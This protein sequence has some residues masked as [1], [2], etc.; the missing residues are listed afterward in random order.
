MISGDRRGGFNRRKALAA[1]VGGGLALSSLARHAGAGAGAASGVRTLRSP[2]ELRSSYDYVIVGAGSSGCVVAHRLG[3]AG[4]R[5][6]LLEAGG[7]ATLAAIRNPPEW[8]KL[9]GS[10]FD[11]RYLTVPQAGLG[12]RMIR[13]PRGK[14]V[15]GSS[16]INA[17]AY[18]RGHPAAYD[19]WPEGWRVADLLPYFKRAETFSGGAGAWR[20]G[21]GPLHVLSLADVRDRNPVAS[22]FV[23]ASQDLGYPMTSDIGG[24]L[25]TGVGWNQLNIKDGAR[26]DAATAYLGSLKSDTVD[27]LVDTEV[28]GLVIEGGRCSGVRLAERSVRAERE[29]LLCAGA[30]DSPRLLMLSGIGPADQL[31]SFNIPVVVDL[32]DVGRHLE[33]HLLVAGVAYAARREVPRSHY[34]HADAVL[35]VPRT[36]PNDSPEHL[37][38]CLSLPFVLSGVGPLPAPAYV[39]VSC[40]MRPRSRGSVKL[41]SGHPRAPALIDPNYLSEPA[42]L[43]LLVEGV[44]LAREIGASA[45]FAD[46]RT[47]EVYPGPKA[48]TTGD[49]RKFVV[50][51]TDSFHHPVGTCRIGAVV[52]QAL[53]VK[54]VAG[55]RVIDASVF[56]G[57]PQAMT[58]AA[59]IAVAEKAS[60]LVLAG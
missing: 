38:M 17:L 35:Y 36:N 25:T 2:D 31:R 48:K 59:A 52:D 53:R 29:V 41:A 5:V 14:V 6:L 15:G 60:D 9:Q 47:Q 28:L 50:H 30:I 13:C 37:V 57:I 19:R 46:W 51:A 54:G 34:N 3:L 44:S 56:P 4:R 21:S 24:E 43:D 26:H 40:L 18:Q 55:L 12:G 42:D 11:W 45:A 16:T 23:K 33:D 1:T 32:P 8:P 27:L 7:Q 22:A 49:I 58:N 10:E 39:L 20:G